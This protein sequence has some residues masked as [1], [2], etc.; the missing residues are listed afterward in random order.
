[1]ALTH[2]ELI[3]QLLPLYGQDPVRFMRF[4]NAVYL[5]LLSIPEG[6][7]L[8]IAEHCNKAAINLFIK[9]ASVLIIEDT[10]KKNVTDDL[11]E[12]SDDYT[13]IRR[14]PK[15]MPSRPYRK[16]TKRL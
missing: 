6:G 7:I 2:S 13:I 5:K 1:M 9:V 4:Y 15:F 14:C 12:F 16:G 10:W 8:R 3:K 11:L